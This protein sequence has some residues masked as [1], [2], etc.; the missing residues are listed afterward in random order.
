MKQPEC[1]IC[2]L[3]FLSSVLQLSPFCLHVKFSLWQRP[4]QAFTKYN[5]IGILRMKIGIFVFGI[6]LKTWI[7]KQQER[8]SLFIGQLIK[9][10]QLRNYSP[11]Y[12]VLEQL[13]ENAIKTFITNEFYLNYINGDITALKFALKFAFQYIHFSKH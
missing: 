1:H 10:K 5:E 2:F 12:S 9:E 8:I 4:T 6:Q 7:W 3:L 11:Y 13:R